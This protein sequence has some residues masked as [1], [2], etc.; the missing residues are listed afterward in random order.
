MVH[1]TYT[2]HKA[3]SCRVAYSVEHCGIL[4]AA[5]VSCPCKNTPASRV[6]GRSMDTS[7]WLATHVPG[8]TVCLVALRC[9]VLG[10][11]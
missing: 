3:A 11:F 6:G 4:A 8:I 9:S 5:A 7:V 10:V 2:E 1:V